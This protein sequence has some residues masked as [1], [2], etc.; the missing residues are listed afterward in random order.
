MY[1]Y[2]YIYILFVYMPSPTRR[3]QGAALPRARRLSHY[4]N[5]ILNMIINK[6]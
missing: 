3:G 6:Q 4:G 5:I 1:I 2:I